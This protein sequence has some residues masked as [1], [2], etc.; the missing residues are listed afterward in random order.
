M[1]KVEGITTVQNSSQ[2]VLKVLKARLLRVP[3][4]TQSNLMSPKSN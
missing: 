4:L 3:I 2:S 1:Q